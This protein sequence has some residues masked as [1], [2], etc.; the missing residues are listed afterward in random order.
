MRQNPILL[1]EITVCK[2]YHLGGGGSGGSGGWGGR[3]AGSLDCEGTPSLKYKISME[4][5]STCLSF[6]KYNSNTVA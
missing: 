3:G 6:V 1:K 2:L 5:N 4:I